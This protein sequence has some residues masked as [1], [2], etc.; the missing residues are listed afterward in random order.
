[1]L[2]EFLGI[3]LENR[4]VNYPE[5]YE[6]IKSNSDVTLKYEVQ[7]LTNKYTSLKCEIQSLIS[8]KEVLEQKDK[9]ICPKDKNLFKI[10]EKAFSQ[11]LSEIFEET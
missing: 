3:Q 2:K 9:G 7:I 1:M 8:E 6:E 5:K 4:L 10:K 11:S